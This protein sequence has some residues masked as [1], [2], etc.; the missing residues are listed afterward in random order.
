MG[1]PTKRKIA[2]VPTMIAQS[3]Q[4]LAA[5]YFT[6]ANTALL[7]FLQGSNNLELAYMRANEATIMEAGCGLHE[8]LA[9]W[10][11]AIRKGD[12]YVYNEWQKVRKDYVKE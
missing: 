2:S 3:E 10:S 7:H 12:V 4:A 11:Q 5:R 6:L 1:K 9:D 8:E